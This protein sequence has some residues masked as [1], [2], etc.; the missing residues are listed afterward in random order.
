[1]VRHCGLGVEIAK[2]D[3]KSDSLLLPVHPDDV[4]LL[5]LSFDCEFYVDL[6]LPMGCFKCFSS[7]LEW[8]LQEWSGLSAVVHYLDDILLAG[9]GRGD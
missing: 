2:C 6:A 8:E 4:D 9:L 3:I 7:F 5:G 1:M